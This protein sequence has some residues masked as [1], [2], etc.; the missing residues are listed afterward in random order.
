MGN[1]LFLTGVA[2]MWAGGM[3]ALKGI[4]AAQDGA[5]MEDLQNFYSLWRWNGFALTVAWLIRLTLIPWPFWHVWDVFTFILIGIGSSAPYFG[6]NNK[7]PD[8]MV[9]YNL[10]N[11]YGI[12][13]IVLNPGSFLAHNWVGHSLAELNLRKKNLLVLSV[14]REETII[15]F[16]KGPEVFL[17]G[18]EL[19]VFGR[20]RELGQWLSEEKEAVDEG[21]VLTSETGKHIMNSKTWD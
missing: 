7:E 21:Q 5:A 10:S 19:L 13:R 1:A 16:P 15:P 3:W 14:T 11:T 17:A 6:R 4:I 20:A 8:T 12:F 2:L 9:V 18:D